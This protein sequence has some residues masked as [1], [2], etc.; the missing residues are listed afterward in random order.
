MFGKLF[1]KKGDSA[2]N[3]K[4]KKAARP[5]SKKAISKGSKLSCRE[6]GLQLEVVDECGCAVPHDILCCGE[7]MIVSC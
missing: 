5:K 3:K 7:Q 2:M 1:T 4:P 6:C